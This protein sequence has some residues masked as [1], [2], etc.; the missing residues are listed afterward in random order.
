MP[1]AL[2]DCNHRRKVMKEE[3]TAEDMSLCKQKGSDSHEKLEQEKDR[4]NH[5]W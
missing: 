5:I 2:V 3:K 4:E 1:K